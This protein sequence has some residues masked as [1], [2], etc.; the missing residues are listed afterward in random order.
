MY[1]KAIDELRAAIGEAHVSDDPAVLISYSWNAGLGGVP[2]PNRLSPTP[3]AA[4][5]LPGSTE[6]VQSVIKTCLAHGLKFK[7]H[8]TGF[9]SFATV[10]SQGVVAIDLRRM[11]RIH[12]IDPKNKI[13]IIDPYVTAAQLQAEAMKVGLN[14]HIVGA[15]PTHSPLASSTAVFG[16]GITGTSTGNNSRNLLSLEWVSP[17]GDILRIG[18]AGADCGWYTDEGPG[19]GFRGMLRGVSGSFGELGVFTRIGYKLFPWHGGPVLKRTGQHPQIGV[20]IPENFIVEHMVWPNWEKVTEASYMINRSDLAMVLVRVPPN[21]WGL[22]LTAT[23]NDFYNLVTSDKIPEIARDDDAHRCT[24]TIMCSAASKAES[25]YKRGVLNDILAKTSGRIV[26]LDERERGLVANMLATSIYI[27]RVLRPSS[28]LGTGFGVLDSF[29]LLPEV[30]KAGEEAFGKEVKPGGGLM[31]GDREE[32]WSW[33]SE[34]RHLWTENAFSYDVNQADSRGAVLRYVLTQANMIDR[35]GNLG[36]D[37]FSVGPLAEFFGPARTK[38]RDWMRKIKLRFDNHRA[39]DAQFYIALAKP[40]IVSIW[41]LLRRVMLLPVFRPIFKVVM[42]YF[43][44]VGLQSL[45]K[46]RKR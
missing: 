46:P 16:I 15:G 2:K 41:P 25:D 36:F 21:S 18:S 1:E 3:P 17:R 34:R 20:E 24:W 11:N 31:Q 43:A 29:S 19:C 28:A 40:Q 14:C 5:V 12:E 26:E 39:Q 38:A 37:A 33:P 45:M 13:A 32:F 27:P 35:R 6:D 4:V 23:N 42:R 9:G 7:A 22:T 44:T 30:M 8:S 10:G